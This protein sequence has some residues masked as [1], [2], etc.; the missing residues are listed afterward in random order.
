MKD[1]KLGETEIFDVEK[2]EEVM[3]NFEPE[4]ICENDPKLI[5]V[6]KGGWKDEEEMYADLQAY[7][8]Y[9]GQ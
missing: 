9:Q 4:E 1:L 5:L 6:K 3:E 8:L 7:G 2:S